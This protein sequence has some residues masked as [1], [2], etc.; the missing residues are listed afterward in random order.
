MCC[1]RTTATHDAAIRMQAVTAVITD[2][3]PQNVGARQLPHALCF[4]E[5]KPREVLLP[6]VTFSKQ[7]WISLWISSIFP[8]EY[9]GKESHQL[10][11]L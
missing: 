10:A 5:F 6:V 7:F 1:E 9:F 3:L 2:L 4:H 11:C 8:Q